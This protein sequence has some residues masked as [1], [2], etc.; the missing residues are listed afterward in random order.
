MIEAPLSYSGNQQKKGFYQNDKAKLFALIAKYP[1]A[2]LVLTDSTGLLH[3][4]HIP[5][6]LSPDND[7]VIG[8]VSNYH[9]LAKALNKIEPVSIMV[10]L[11]FN[12][13]NGYVSPNY[14]Q[15]QI[16]P[17]W[18]Y[19]NVHLQAE[20]ILI[21]EPNVKYQQMQLSTQFF[22]KEQLI[23]W[24]LDSAPEQIIDKM[25]DAI[26]I[27]K[28]STARICGRYKLSQN[29]SEQTRAQISEGLLVN[30]EAKLA[31]IMDN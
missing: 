13:D 5:F 26:T 31:S 25:L 17:T 6:H 9:P 22:E 30:D 7:Y 8:H 19:A 16:V 12:G 21:E 2:S 15:A 11:V 27:F 10:Y 28:L 4:S 24:T 14:S 23:P 3:V 1:L 18:N 20:A 29:K